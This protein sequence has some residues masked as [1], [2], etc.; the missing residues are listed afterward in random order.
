MFS[1]LLVSAFGT[2]LCFYSITKAGFV[3]PECIPASPQYVT[4]TTPIDRWNYDILTDEGE[5][6]WRRIVQVITTKCTHLPQ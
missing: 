2:R 1:Y 6:E 5:T 4:D 3:S